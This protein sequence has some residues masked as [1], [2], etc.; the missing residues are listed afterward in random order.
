MDVRVAVIGTVIEALTCVMSSNGEASIL[1]ARKNAAPL[2]GEIERPHVKHELRIGPSHTSAEYL[3]QC[4]S[5]FLRFIFHHFAR[6]QDRPTNTKRP[7]YPRRIFH[8]HRRGSP[9]PLF[10]GTNQYWQ[11]RHR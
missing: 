6:K 1:F 3:P 5:K 9:P 11:H 7:R 10:R 8:P 2:V 4:L